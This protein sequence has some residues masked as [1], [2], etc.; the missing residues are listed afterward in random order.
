MMEAIFSPENLELFKQLFLA[1]SLGAIIGAE[2]RLAHK[3]A[4]MR[5]FALVALGSALFTVIS[6]VAFA[7]YAGRPGFDPS[8]IA[9]QIVVGIGFLG[10]GLIIFKE[11]KVRGLTTAA[12][13]WVTAA[14]GMA[15]G[16]KLYSLAV[17]ATILTLLIFLVLWFLE[18]K[19]LT[20]VPFELHKDE[21]N[22]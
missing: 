17:F 7:D 19:Y 3:T 1:A 4:G 13:L 11:S 18:Y 22:D 20:R 6:V 16:Y 21:G 12:G 5:T 15:V 2:R 10:A 9:S 14:I 8:R